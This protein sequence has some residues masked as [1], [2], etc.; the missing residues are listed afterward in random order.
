[1]EVLST[2]KREKTAIV[3]TFYTERGEANIKRPSSETV[4]D[5]EKEKG[6]SDMGRCRYERMAV[7]CNL[8]S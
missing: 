2:K 4:R 7:N 3:H 5:Q 8:L 1:M 6:N